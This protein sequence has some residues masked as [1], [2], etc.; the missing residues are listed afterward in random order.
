[1]VWIYPSDKFPVVYT[2]SFFFLP[3]QPTH[4]IFF[5][6]STVAFL[7]LYF[8]W[9]MPICSWN[10]LSYKI[11]WFWLP[12]LTYNGHPEEIW[13]S[14][15]PSLLVSLDEIITRL[16]ASKIMITSAFTWCDLLRIVHSWSSSC[17]QQSPMLK[18]MQFGRSGKLM[19]ELAL[20]EMDWHH[21]FR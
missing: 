2:I 11:L 19:K 16:Q 9:A 21:I 20:K 3:I 4:L 5:I 15:H 12:K 7:I 13:R 10:L 6:L 14:V 18:M 1:M 17:L 8:F